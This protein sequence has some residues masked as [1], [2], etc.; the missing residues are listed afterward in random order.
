[1]AEN[2][3]ITVNNGTRDI[4]KNLT[5]VNPNA[6]DSD[7]AVVASALNGLTT[8]TLVN[9]ERVVRNSISLPTAEEPAT[10]LSPNLTVSMNGSA[11][12]DSY[13]MVKEGG[14]VSA[15]FD[16]SRFGSGVITVSDTANYMSFDSSSNRITQS[17]GKWTPDDG[18]NTV[19][20]V[21]LAS[22]GTYDSASKV[23]TVT[24]TAAGA[25]DEP[26]GP[27]EPETP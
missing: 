14:Y 2:L 1:M 5:N 22:D 27:A 20:T 3:I 18:A 10:L 25:A 11:V 15:Y 8:N 12:G 16:V 19:V 13:E 17:F 6:A 21:S 23:F 26:G 24:Y 4:S 7:L 9:L